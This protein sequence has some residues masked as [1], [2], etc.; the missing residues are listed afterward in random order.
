M[1]LEDIK[2]RPLVETLKVLDITDEEYF[3]NDIVDLMA[4]F[5]ME[6]E[7]YFVHRFFPKEDISYIDEEYDSVVKATVKTIGSIYNMYETLEIKVSY[8]NLQIDPAYRPSTQP[9]AYS[10][11]GTSMRLSQIQQQKQD[12]DDDMASKKYLLFQIY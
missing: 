3:G 4:Q 7:E 5:G 1:K 10:G 8:K 11:S 12:S 6:T 9:Q 2:L